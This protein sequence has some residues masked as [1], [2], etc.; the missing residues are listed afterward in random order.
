MNLRELGK[1][2]SRG[3]VFVVGGFW[4][5]IHSLLTEGIQRGW[6][7]TSGNQALLLAKSSATEVVLFSYDQ[8]ATTWYTCLAEILRDD[9]IL[10]ISEESS[11]SKFL[12]FR[13]RYLMLFNFQSYRRSHAVPEDSIFNAQTFCPSDQ[14]QPSGENCSLPS[15]LALTHLSLHVYEASGCRINR[16]RR[17]W[18]K[19]KD[20]LFIKYI[21]NCT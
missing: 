6:C 16:F 11:L 19:K 14:P 4:P 13:L 2:K 8:G 20:F 10:F 1:N 18:G 12:F 17:H 21:S 7:W 5:P 15:L 9:A 3:T